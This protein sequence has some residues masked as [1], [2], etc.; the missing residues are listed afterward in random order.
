[1]CLRVNSLRTVVWSTIYVTGHGTRSRVLT[2][3]AVDLQMLGRQS[4]E[5]HDAITGHVRKWTA[6]VYYSQRITPP[7][8]IE[9][10][11]EKVMLQYG[12]VK[13]GRS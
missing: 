4:E 6:P 5:T 1:M 11:G 3:A 7:H 10:E 13:R 8:I 2:A 9:P 12:E